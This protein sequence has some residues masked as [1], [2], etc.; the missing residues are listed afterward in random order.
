MTVIFVPI[1]IVGC[2]KSTIFRAL[3]DLYPGLVH[4]ENDVCGNKSTFYSRIDQLVKDKSVQGILLDRN[5]HLEQHRKE[6]V[7]KY[8][9]PEVKLVALVFVN[10][11]ELEAAKTLAINRIRER[12]DNHPQ[13]KSQ[14]KKGQ[15]MMIINSFARDFAPFDRNNDADGQFDDVL[16]MSIG[17]DSSFKNVGAI[18]QYY[19]DFLGNQ[20]LAATNEQI[21]TAVEKSLCFTV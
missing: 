7:R 11:S 12:G 5:N 13:I 3:A 6:I 4:I 18:S 19:Q 9:T 1:S 15:A 10:K 17:Q 8:R 16:T 2:G 20:E 21:K 14:S